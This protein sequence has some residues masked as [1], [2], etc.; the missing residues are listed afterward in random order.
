MGNKRHQIYFDGETQ[1]AW[2]MI[3]EEISDQFDSKSEFFQHTV[4][5]ANQQGVLFAR[6]TV[7]EKKRESLKNQIE[8]LN[9][10]IN[11]LEERLEED[12]LEEIS[13]ENITQDMQEHDEYDRAMR[14]LEKKYDDSRGRLDKKMRSVQYW[15]KELGVKPQTLIQHIEEQAEA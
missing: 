13:F 8:A 2:E 4:K 3:E 12:D 6:K 11:G 14:I 1:E 15:S 9:A 10:Q 7:L 5:S